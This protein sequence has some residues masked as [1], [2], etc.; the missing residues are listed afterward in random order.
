MR[1]YMSLFSLV[2]IF[3]TWKSCLCVWKARKQSFIFGLDFISPSMNLQQTPV[4]QAPMIAFATFSTPANLTIRKG[5]LMDLLP[6]LLPF[7][8]FRICFANGCW[9]C[10]CT[11]L[12][13]NTGFLLLLD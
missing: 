3:F 6:L 11:V 9:A 4:N 5:T 1:Q 7:F 2:N 8:D 12:M 13:P 10:L